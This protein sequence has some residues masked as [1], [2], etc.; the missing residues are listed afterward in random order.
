MQLAFL[1]AEDILDRYPDL[2]RKARETAVLKDMCGR[3]NI[4]VL[5]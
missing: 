3:N 4:P 5:E 1:H 2:P